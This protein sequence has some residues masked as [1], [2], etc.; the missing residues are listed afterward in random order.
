MPN[1]PVG[2][3]VSRSHS[4]AS[5]CLFGYYIVPCWNA[6]LD[7]RHVST[8]TEYLPVLPQQVT[9]H[10]NSSLLEPLHCFLVMTIT[11]ISVTVSCQAS[12]NPTDQLFGP[13]AVRLNAPI[14]YHYHISFTL[15]FYLLLFVYN[16]YNPLSSL[17]SLLGNSF[18]K[19]LAILSL[20]NLVAV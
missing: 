5:F 6:I 8:A 10:S 9:L 4:M 13:V 12:P 16:I 1:D 7:G 18:K 17:S 2:L 14:Y 15:S 3:G 19:N 20:L 11:Y